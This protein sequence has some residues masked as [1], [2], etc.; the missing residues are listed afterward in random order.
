M[1]KSALAPLLI[2]ALSLFLVAERAQSQEWDPF[3][4][5]GGSERKPAAKRAPAQDQRAPDT[6]TPQFLD[7]KSF[8][9]E[10]GD[11]AP[12][13]A[14]DGSGLPF[15]LWR[16]L[17]VRALEELI[18]ELKIPP[19]SPALHALWRRLITSNV[20][21]PKGGE[22]DQQ[23]MALR[24]EALYRSGLL[25]EA[26][27]ELSRIPAGNALVATLAA[28][29]EIGLG[30]KDQGCATAR[31]GGPPTGSLPKPLLG[32][33][34]LISGYCAAI[35]HDTAG[36]GLAADLARE[37]GL[38]NSAGLQALYAFSVGSKPKLAPDQAISLLDYRILEATGAPPATAD[39]LKQARPSLLA[40]LA[41]DPNTQPDLK[42]TAA[43]AAARVNAL[44]PD[45][46]AAIYRTQAVP[47]A[48][49]A[50]SAE[51]VLRRAQLFVAAEKEQ[52]PLKK[53]RLIRS[54][55]GRAFGRRELTSAR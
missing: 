47:S 54:F 36:A 7:E 3:D 30:Q 37:Q 18:A 13:M 21:P 5:Y 15:E 26:S 41:L 55:H 48:P 23:F 10:R 39:I 14:T 16:G 4:T 8:A 34:A 11:L 53:V 2:A 49:V 17:N 38:T 51:P 27:R 29:N 46:L 12:V 28:R 44:M 1:R 9:V 43:E 24:L 6:T 19:R 45:E 22:V 52:T 42:L 33:A 40:A 20:T 32:Q 35:A 50:V 25:T 31:S